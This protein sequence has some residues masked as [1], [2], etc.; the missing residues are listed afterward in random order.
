[1]PP[2]RVGEGGGGAG[3]GDGLGDGLGLAD[4]GE[5]GSTGGGSAGGGSGAASCTMFTVR[6]LT[7]TVATRLLVEPLAATTRVTVDSP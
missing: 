5:G 7:V 6:S 4:G 1:M 3:V 2:R